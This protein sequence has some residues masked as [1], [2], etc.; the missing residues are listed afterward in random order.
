MGRTEM[1]L[2]RGWNKVCL[3]CWVGLFR[4][5]L[6]GSVEEGM[7]RLLIRVSRNPIIAWYYSPKRSF[8]LYDP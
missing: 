2:E 4:D 3:T 6:G 7:V 1:G 5:G 8:L